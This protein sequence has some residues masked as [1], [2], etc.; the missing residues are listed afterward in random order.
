MVQI[1]FCN[2]VTEYFVAKQT[3]TRVISYFYAELFLDDELISQINDFEEEC[4]D[5]YF[6]QNGEDLMA[7]PDE[8]IRLTC[9]R[10]ILVILS[11]RVDSI[12]LLSS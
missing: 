10:Y 1:Y 5:A 9:D 6:H 4:L 2:A 12:F 7:S 11:Y 8:R 3:M